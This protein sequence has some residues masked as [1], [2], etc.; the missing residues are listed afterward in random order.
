M[1]RIALLAASGCAAAAMLVVPAGAAMAAP[2][3]PNTNVAAQQQAAVGSIRGVTT[4]VV[5]RHGMQVYQI[6]AQVSGATAG[7]QVDLLTANGTQAGGFKPYAFSGGNT[8]TTWYTPGSMAGNYKLQIGNQ[9]SAPFYL[10]ALPG[11]S[12]GM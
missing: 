3:A 11:Q 8:I 4:T 7:Q 1:K 10:A 5:Q 12:L 6:K 2:A 9:V